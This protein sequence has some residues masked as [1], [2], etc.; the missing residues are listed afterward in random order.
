MA[1]A[2]VPAISL[3]ALLNNIKD[4][5]P[6]DSVW[7]DRRRPALITAL[8]RPHITSLHHTPGTLVTRAALGQVV[9]A[10]PA[11]SPLPSGASHLHQIEAQLRCGEKVSAIPRVCL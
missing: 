3:R 8:P 9:P 1:A 7:P 6:A 10:R 2:R 4:T 11:R 5:S